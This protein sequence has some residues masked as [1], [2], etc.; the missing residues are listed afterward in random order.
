MEIENFIEEYKDEADTNIKIN[1]NYYLHNAI[2]KSQNILMFSTAKGVI[3]QGLIAYTIFVEHI[4]T[5]A[6]AADMLKVKEEEKTYKEK[7][8]DYKK[9]EEYKKLT[10]NNIKMARLSNFKLKL[11]LT[12]VFSRSPSDIPLKHS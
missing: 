9:S 11:I 10:D 8:E 3:D 2:L 5:I 1:P 12:E 4:E 7:I 6:E